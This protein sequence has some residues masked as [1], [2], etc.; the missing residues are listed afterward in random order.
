[1][2]RVKWQLTGPVTFARALMHA[3]VGPDLAVRVATRAVRSRAHALG[4]EVERQLGPVDQIVFIDE[5]SLVGIAH[6]GF[7]VLPTRAIAMMAE[8]VDELRVVATVGI[9]CCG[10]TDWPAVID[11]GATILSLPTDDSLVRHGAALASFLADGG[12]VA[13]GAVPT[14]EPL[15]TSADRLWRQL[16]DLWCDLVRAGCDPALLRTNALVTPVCGLA[17]HGVSQAERVLRITNELAV[18]V[19]DQAAATRMSLGA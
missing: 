4:Q 15:G 9:H 5:P 1:V 16:S 19:H 17:R 3:G 14:H 8:V 13:W 11:T 18:R 7:A 2:A 12:H 6:P 10:R